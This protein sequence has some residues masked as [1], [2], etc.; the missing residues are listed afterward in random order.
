MKR[1]WK[2][3]ELIGNFILPE[4]EREILPSSRT[5]AAAHNQLGFAVL[6]KFFQLEAR[7][8]NHKNEVAKAVVSFIAQQLELAYEN[9]LQYTG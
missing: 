3:E 6:L 5:N 9:C 8:P 2:A 4:H 1:Q 7:F